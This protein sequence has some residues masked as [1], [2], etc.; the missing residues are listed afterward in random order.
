MEFSV[1]PTPNPTSPGRLAE[2]LAAPG[3]GKYFTDHMVTVEWTPEAGWHDARVRPYG[4]LSLDPATHV[5]HYGQSIFEGFKAYRQPDGGIATFRPEFNGERFNRSAHRLA[6]P[7]LAV[8]DFVAGVRCAGVRRTPPGCRTA[9]RPAS[10]CG[11][12]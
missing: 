8:E 7:E 3:F 1:E 5:F 10:T 6:L 11:R 9:A 12:S 2:I 4:P